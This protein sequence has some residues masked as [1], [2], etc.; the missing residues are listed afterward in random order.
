MSQAEFHQRFRAA[1]RWAVHLETRNSYDADMPALQRW[2]D[3]YRADPADRSTWWTPWHTDV[4]TA[5]SR[6][7]VI[8]RARLYSEPESDYIRVGRDLT[9]QLIKAGED[10]R[11]LSRRNA[12]QLLVPVNDFW[13]ID[14]RTLAIAHHGGAGELVDVEISEDPTLAH[15]YSQAFEAVWAEARPHEP[16]TGG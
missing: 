7:V 1:R 6:G 4:N 9:W 2:M 8:R 10:V 13:L 14:G 5:V 15:V 11:W 16:C 12:G 3:G